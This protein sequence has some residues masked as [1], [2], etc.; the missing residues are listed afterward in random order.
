MFRI[1]KEMVGREKMNFIEETVRIRISEKDKIRGYYIIFCN[2]RANCFR[3]EEYVIEKS[4]VDL[5]KK[6]G[7]E[8]EVLVE[9][10]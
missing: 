7:I 8:F 6:S 4:C 1:I 2:C 3:N 5:L 9:S 10:K